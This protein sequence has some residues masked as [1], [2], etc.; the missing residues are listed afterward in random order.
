MGSRN[1]Y[2]GCR[3][4]SI[5]MVEAL[6]IAIDRG[7]EPS[8]E[9]IRDVSSLLGQPSKKVNAFLGRYLDVFTRLIQKNCVLVENGELC[10]YSWNPRAYIRYFPVSIDA[11]GTILFI[12]RDGRVETIA[13]P[14]HRTHDIEGHRVEIIDPR[15]N[16]IVEVTK[17][18]DGYPI[19][20]YYNPLLK[21]WIPATRYLLHN[22]VYWGRRVEVA[23]ISEIVNPYVKLAH[24]YALDMGL[25]ELLK[26]YSGWTFTF[27]LKLPEPALLRPNVELYSV[28]D[29][30]LLLLNARRPDGQL[31]TVSE[32]S[33][34]LK[35]DHVPIVDAE[36][37][38]L[39]SLREF[40]DECK[41]DLEYR[42]TMVRYSGGDNFR[43]YT[44]EIKSKV[45]P[46]AV[47]V[48]YSS[49]P[50]SL[51][52]LASYGYG[53]QAIDLLVDYGDIKAIGS[54][55]VRLYHELESLISRFIESDKLLNVL[56][57]FDL[58]KQ[59]RGEVMRA[60]RRG[61]VRRFTRKLVAL[62]SGKTVYEARDNL[63]KFIN[64]L[65]KEKESV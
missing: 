33:R 51:L 58:E 17:R 13:Y 50:K 11:V 47:R 8:P 6:K 57:K 46:E 25:Y 62:L 44:L 19:T 38:D 48:K 22:M 21:K 3:G 31:L 34:L 7:Y 9:E 64:Y 32:S 63:H 55:L 15:E 53:E 60:R 12:D 41:M 20:F 42:S 45:Y 26:G 2:S 28:S 35:I 49:D 56:R 10:I 43:P 61:D 23:D 1:L 4:N 30:E 40:I 29:V 14:S 59:L 27:I 65:L 39:D 36:I 54:E 37:S 18:I 52:L 16:T 24:E 5:C